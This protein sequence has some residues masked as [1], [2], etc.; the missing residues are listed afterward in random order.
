[1]NRPAP[2]KI[3]VPLVARPIASLRLNWRDSDGAIVRLRVNF[4]VVEV[5]RWG[6]LGYLQPDGGAAISPVFEKPE[7]RY[8][9]RQRTRGANSLDYTAVA[10]GM[11][12]LWTISVLVMS[13]G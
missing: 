9:N 7:T 8:Q 6:G 2:P 13:P 1:M 12:R 4:G 5:P 11:Y 10:I 3:S